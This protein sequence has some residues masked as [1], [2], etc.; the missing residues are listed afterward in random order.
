MYLLETQ[1]FIDLKKG[2]KEIVDKIEKIPKDKIYTSSLVVAEISWALELGGD[3][4]PTLKDELKQYLEFIIE[5]CNILDFNI[6][7]ALKYG[8]LKNILDKEKIQLEDLDLM[9]VSICL[10][11]KLV[12]VTGNK[13][14][15]KKYQKISNLKVELWN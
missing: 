9:N 6:N 11:L 7:S 15:F 13:E 3:K 1:I 5:N 2:K 4:N 8:E 12:F 14:K 10:S